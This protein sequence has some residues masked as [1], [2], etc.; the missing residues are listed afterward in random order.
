VLCWDGVFRRDSECVPVICATFNGD[1]KQLDDVHAASTNV[2]TKVGYEQRVLVT[3]A[4]GH[5]AVPV[6]LDGAVSCNKSRSYVTTCGICGWVREMECRKVH[7]LP[8]R[9]ANTKAAAPVMF[10]FGENT[11]VECNTGYMVAAVGRNLTTHPLYPINGSS[12]QDLRYGGTCA[13]DCELEPRDA[14]WRTADVERNGSC[15]QLDAHTGSCVRWSRVQLVQC[16]AASCPPFSSL[17][18]AAGTSLT[19]PLAKATVTI[20][21]CPPGF[22]FDSNV[23]PESVDAR[24]IS[25]CTYLRITS[26]VASSEISN[27]SMR[28]DAVEMSGRNSSRN[29]SIAAW[30]QAFICLAAA[31]PY[32][33]DING[34]NIVRAYRASGL[35]IPPIPKNLSIDNTSIGRSYLNSGVSAEVTC[36][37]GHRKS[38]LSNSSCE[39]QHPSSYA[40]LCKEGALN[41]TERCVPLV[42]PKW[43]TEDEYHVVSQPYALYNDTIKITCERGYK[44]NATNSSSQVPASYTAR[45]LDNCA[46]SISPAVVPKCISSE[47]TLPPNTHWLHLPLGGLLHLQS[48][49]IECDF[50]SV[51][52]ASQR[53]AFDDE[54]EQAANIK[55]NAHAAAICGQNCTSTAN[56]SLCVQATAHTA[57]GL[58]A[59]ALAGSLPN[60][61][62][63][64]YLIYD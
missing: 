37:R 17:Q 35:Y 44:F 7:C 39:L 32:T 30:Q 64:Q 25:D 24:C 49:W 63:T 38:S 12:C 2:T 9:T 60:L 36:F 43:Q 56:A 11:T 41:D 57:E 28:L 62:L 33:P 6:D 8:S 26:L 58:G 46:Y 1:A 20:V 22:A 27:A 53:V 34:V 54:A 31:C 18:L 5:R 29:S 16:S 55:A 45:C 13:D 48:A 59:A 40:V 52:V 42:C 3:C 14:E 21:S 61:L 19:R 4:I 15:L 47:C 50:G 23:G 10:E 51:L